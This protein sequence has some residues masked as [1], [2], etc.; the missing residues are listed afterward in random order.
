M[1]ASTVAG[2]M[3]T[4]PIWSFSGNKLYYFTLCPATNKKRGNCGMRSI[5]MDPKIILSFVLGIALAGGVSFFALRQPAAPAPAV[6]QGEPEEPQ[7]PEAVQP[8][9]E[10]A[11]TVPV[12]AKVAAPAPAPHPHLPAIEPLAVE[13]PA[14]K[15]PAVE[16][17]KAAIRE[18]TAPLEPTSAAARI[19]EA[20]APPAPPEFAPAPVPAKLPPKPAEP[21]TVTLTQGTILKIRVLQDLSSER[22]RVGD[23]FLFTLDEPLV[24]DGF[25]I[26]ERGAHGEGTVV[27]VEQAGRVKGLSRLTLELNWFDSSDGQQVAVK[28]GSLE[29]VGAESKKQ[30]AAKIG[31]AAAIGAA[32]GAAADGG[33]GAGAGAAAGAAA[34]VGAVLLTRGKAVV[35]PSESQLIFRVDE[36]VMLTERAGSQF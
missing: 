20:K 11:R 25:V 36:P 33:K 19:L 26:A 31:I 21:H 12:V 10:T 35:I 6:V 18:V 29:R 23:R 17:D 28:T 16:Q 22:N 30:D 1:G 27:E 7:P 24:V 8:V 5:Y 2:A 15:P 32:I 34:G 3:G 14:V 13:P 4:G 9:P